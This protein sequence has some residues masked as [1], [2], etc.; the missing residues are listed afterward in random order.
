MFN[1]SLCLPYGSKVAQLDLAWLMTW[2][3]WSPQTEAAGAHEHLELG[4]TQGRWFW[5]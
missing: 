2:G 5:M 3:R 4:V 1:N